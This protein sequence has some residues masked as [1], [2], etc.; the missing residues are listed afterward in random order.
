MELCVLAKIVLLLA[1]VTMVFHF[2]IFGFTIGALVDILFMTLLVFITNRYCEYWIAKAIVIFA[3]IGTI[4]YFYECH[5]KQ[6]KHA[7]PRFIRS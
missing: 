2:C 5:T 7:D 1:I 6:Q 3:I 4:T